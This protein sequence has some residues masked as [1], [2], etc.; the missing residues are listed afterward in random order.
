[1]RRSLRSTFVLALTSCV[2]FSSSRVDAHRLHVRTLDLP[3][4]QSA[5]DLTVRP[6]ASGTP[7]GVT[8]PDS[9]VVTKQHVYIAYQ[10]DTPPTGSALKSTIVQYDRAGHVV[11]TV[12][13]TGRCDGMRWNPYTHTLWATVNEDSYPGLYVI[14]PQRSTLRRYAFAWPTPHGGGYDDIGFSQGKA[15]VS[16]SNPTLNAAGVNVF[17]AVDEVTLQA[18]GRAVV[19]PVISGNALVKDTTTNTFVHINAIDPDSMQIAPNG[20]V[21]LVDQAG[22][23][24]VFIHNPGTKNQWLSRI[25]TGTQLDDID[26]TRSAH[27]A[28]YIVD[29]HKN[30]T[31]IVTAARWPIGQI[32]TEAPSDSG[33]AGFVGTLDLSTGNIV[34][35]LIGFGSPTGLIWVDDSAP[36]EGS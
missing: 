32:W 28:L 7:N 29:S 10:N 4:T 6:F 1:M 35:Q 20:D 23:E 2:I 14:S 11:R 19:S 31:S 34:P 13:V 36:D 33:V 15:F 27:G 22:T 21:V 24:L 16:G 25:P 8:N 9:I 12:A 5:S 30:L 3:V 18:D 26:V 17:P